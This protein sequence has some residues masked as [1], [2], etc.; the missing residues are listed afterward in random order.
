MNKYIP[1]IICRKCNKVFWDYE[2]NKGTAKCPECKEVQDKKLHGLIGASIC[3]NSEGKY[4]LVFEQYKEMDIFPA[5]KLL[6]EEME[7]LSKN[8]EVNSD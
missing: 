4:V 1:R 3:K 2:D 6:E 5:Y 7:K 8:D